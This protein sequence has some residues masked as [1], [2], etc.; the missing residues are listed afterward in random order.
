MFGYEI[1]CGFNLI[2]HYNLHK[3]Q[4]KRPKYPPNVEQVCVYFEQQKMELPDY[5]KWDDPP[6]SPS[7]KRSEF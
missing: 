1:L 4:L 2:C 3:E 6:K 7:K 5:C